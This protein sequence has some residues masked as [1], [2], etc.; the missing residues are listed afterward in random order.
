MKK[1][2]HFET[3]VLAGVITSVSYNQIRDD[4]FAIFPTFVTLQ[5]VTVAGTPQ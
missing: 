3:S 4:F 5:Y 1:R 2:C